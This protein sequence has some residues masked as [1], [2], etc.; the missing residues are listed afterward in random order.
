MIA[1]FVRIFQAKLTEKP[2][3]RAGCSLT[4][5]N[6]TIRFFSFSKPNK[7]IQL[8]S[9]VKKSN[10]NFRFKSHCL[11]VLHKFD[12]FSWFSRADLMAPQFVCLIIIVLSRLMIALGVGVG[13]RAMHLQRR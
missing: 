12:Q 9:L 8:V 13:V 5:N 10:G 1:Y 4:I 2:K 6:L 3:K 7:A 11:L